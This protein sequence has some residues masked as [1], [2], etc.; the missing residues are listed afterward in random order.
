MLQSEEPTAKRLVRYE[1][2][3]VL[4]DIDG[5]LITTH[6]AG[7]RAFVVCLKEVFGIEDDL[8]DLEFAGGTDR[9]LLARILERHGRRPTPADERRFFQC[10]PRALND[11][12]FRRPAEPLPGVRRLLSRLAEDRRFVIG[13]LTGNIPRCAQL[14][15]E[16]ADLEGYFDFGGFGGE[17]AH[18][19][20]VARAAIREMMIRCGGTVPPVIWVV[21]D[22][23]FDVEAA[24]AISAFALGV[25]GGRYCV[26]DLLEAG[27]AAAVETL[28]YIGPD[29]FL[30]GGDPQVG[31][32]EE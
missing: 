19:A 24:K 1:R 8:S 30:S 16:S 4:F 27:A 26:R 29:F 25:A 32:R 21:G 18:R 3:A 10:L 17:H 31:G 6:G 20:D 9:A 23:I 7:R 15:L 14:K 22:T 28:E 11:L 5:T 13:L 2:A 12:L